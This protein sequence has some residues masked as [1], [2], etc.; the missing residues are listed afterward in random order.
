MRVRSNMKRE[1]DDLALGE[2]LL[3]Q[4]DGPSKKKAKTKPRNSK[5][6]PAQP[7]VDPTYGQ[8]TV[9]PGIEDGGLPNDLDLEHEDVSDAMAYLMSVR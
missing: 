9:L 6:K 4:D 1:L 5:R 8:R 7:V 2:N 3:V